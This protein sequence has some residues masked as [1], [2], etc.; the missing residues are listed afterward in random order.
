MRQSYELHAGRGFRFGAQVPGGH[1]VGLFHHPLAGFRAPVFRFRLFQ[2]A[3]QLVHLLFQAAGRFLRCLIEGLQLLGDPFVGVRRLPYASVRTGYAVRLSFT[4]QQ[5]SGK[6]GKRLHPSVFL[7]P[8]LLPFINVRFIPFQLD[9][10][11]FRHVHVES[12]TARHRFPAVTGRGEYSV[13][14]R[15]EYQYEDRYD[16]VFPAAQDF[17]PAKPF[18][19]FCPFG[20][21]GTGFRRPCAFRGFPDGHVFFFHV[22]L[23]VFHSAGVV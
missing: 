9:R 22:T 23:P 2:P 4:F 20:G 15:K 16:D 17:L 7:A 10:R 3:V 18:F 1:P 8:G 19:R 6:V 5:P 12:R 21:D 13:E 14:D 11:R